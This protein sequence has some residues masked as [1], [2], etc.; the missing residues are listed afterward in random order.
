MCIRDRYTV[1]QIPTLLVITGIWFLGSQLEVW[2]VPLLYTRMSWLIITTT[3][4]I[5]I[6]IIVRFAGIKK[7]VSYVKTKIKMNSSQMLYLVGFFG[8]K[9][10]N[11]RGDV[12]FSHLSRWHDWLSEFVSR[13]TSKQKDESNCNS[14]RNNASG[15]SHIQHKTIF[16]VCNINT[17]EVLP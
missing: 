3:A 4:T 10:T 15:Y 2:R 7:V 5:T 11:I 1:W 12:V 13:M 6:I 9:P 8:T 14:R 16:L 17:L